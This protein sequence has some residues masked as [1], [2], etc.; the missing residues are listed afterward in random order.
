MHAPMKKNRT[1]Q[2][3]QSSVIV[4]FLYALNKV[5]GLYRFRLF[6]RAF[7]TT[8]EADAF[9][10]ANQLPELFYV[11]IAGGALAAAFIPVYTKYLHDDNP[12]KAKTS[13]DV[14][15]TTLTLVFLVLISVCG[16]AALFSPQII[17]YVLLPDSAASTQRLTADLMRIILLNTILFG[18]SGVITSLLN[19]HQHFILPASA[20]IMLDVGYILSFWLFVPTMG[21][22]GVAWG[23]VLGAILHIGIQLPALLRFGIRLRPRLAFHL[24]GVH[25]IIKLMGPRIIMLG[26]IQAADVFWV[27]V[28]SSLPEGQV[29][30]YNYA[31]TLMQLPETL[32]G[33][34]IAIVIFPTLSELYN[35][36]RL[37]QLKETA[38]RILRIIWLL[39]IPSAAGLILL[40]RPAI[41]LLLGGGAFD[42]GSSA[43]VYSALIFLS[44]RVVSE[45]TLEIVARLFYARHDTYTP[46]RGYIYW[47]IINIAAIYLFVG[48]MGAAG[49]A[50][51]STLA[52]T[53]LSSWLFWKNRQQLGDMQE[54]ELLRSFARSAL[55]T[56]A[57]TVVILLIG[58]L[59]LGTFVFLGVG[60]G[61][62]GVVY[63]VLRW[64]LGGEEIEATMAFIRR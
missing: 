60:S 8:G 54:G 40:G 42:A 15:N 23:T 64:L 11:L 14:A 46:M 50:L 1:R 7:G 18:I 62:G 49:I 59:E 33:T 28:A 44:V 38:L 27:R 24:S 12:D 16:L 19:A 5:T 43:L 6:G 41:D 10:A 21:I 57:M 63:L 32:F 22:F 26:A 4:M 9:T 35:A 3:L 48:S 37:A 53:F 56:L 31:F 55:A 39:T 61:I 17:Q 13:A 2:L 51:A 34:A 25:E 52:F 36:G 29:S 58:Q 20:P 30:G 47:L 45:A